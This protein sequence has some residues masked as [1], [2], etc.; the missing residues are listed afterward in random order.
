MSDVARFSFVPPLRCFHAEWNRAAHVC[1]APAR[2]T[3]VSGDT[4][5]GPFFCDEH[6]GPKD[7]PIEGALLVRRVTLTLDV[8]FAGASAMPAI[9][10]ADALA[11]LERAIADIGGV[12]NLHQVYDVVGR[13]EP[14]PARRKHRRTAVGA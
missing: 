3:R 14:P 9:A 12:I 2:W 4:Q 11:R 8:S 5:P 1:G 13:Y 7:T 10:R 6:R